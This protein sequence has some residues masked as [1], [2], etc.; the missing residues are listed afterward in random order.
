MIN[1]SYQN[2]FKFGYNE[3]P[4]TFR[5]KSQDKWW[6]QYGTCQRKTDS[7]RQECLNTAKLIRQQVIGEIVL[8]LSGGI[9]SEVVLQSFIQEKIPIKIAIMEFKD[10]LNAHDVYFARKHCDRYSIKPYIFSLDLLNFWENDLLNYAEPVYSPSPQLLPHMWLM[11][12]VDGYPIMGSGECL[13]VKRRPDNYIPGTSP[14]EWDEWDL[15]EKEKIASWYRHLIVRNR[16]G[17][18]GFF[19]YN[20][21]I[22]LSYLLDPTVRKMTNC[23]FIG[24]L[25]SE[26]SKHLIYSNHFNLEERDK[27]HGF[28]KVMDLD[29]KY[30]KILLQKF[31]DANEYFISPVKTLIEQMSYKASLEK[32]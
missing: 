25:T 15:Y 2:H 22:I 23:E 4:F 27:Y 7:F 16:E 29:I 14:Y 12:Q 31:S 20:P 17:C 11:D 9:D 10:G 13:L 19:Q 8:L 3:N 6:V 30:R 28:E 18:A 26:S 21:E 32:N 1:L 5:K 24:K